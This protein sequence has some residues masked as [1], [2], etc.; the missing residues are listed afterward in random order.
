MTAQDAQARSSVG[1]QAIRGDD[2]AT[3]IG[4]TNPARE[5]QS[6]DRV[7]P[8]RTDHGTLPNLK[9]SFA[10]SHNRLEEGGWA[11]Q[12]TVREMPI[13]TTMAGVNMRLKAGA[14]REMH[15][16]KEA[17]WAFMLK[18]RA[19][20]TSVDQNL[21]TYQDDVG[22]GEGWNFPAG[23]PHS[24]QGLDDDGC[25]FL[26]VFDDGSFNEDETFLLTDWL[27][28]TPKE[29][30]SKNFGVP[31]SAFA[32]IPDKELYIFPSKVPGP[33]AADRVAGLGPVPVSFTHRMIRID[34]VS[35]KYGT[36]RIMDSTLFPAATTI[37][38]ALVEVE[39]GGMRELHWHPNADEWQ[40]HI[41]GQARMTVFASGGAAQ[42]FDYQAGDVG[43]VP[44]S[45]PHYL[46]NTAKTTFRF[47]E[48]FRSPKFEDVPLAQW[49]AFT[50][51]ELVRAHLKIDEAVLAKIPQRKMP[52]VGF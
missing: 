49:L 20:V 11:R 30:L 32:N 36:V 8:P 2:G 47:L 35:M 7:T 40:Y 15:W 41:A 43:Y 21:C 27:S 44:K 51:H 37:T 50:P 5:A 48:M 1:S 6:A 12:T 31:E 33:L 10:D 26:L 17:E 25:E 13:A 39:P 18:G 38:A 14:I 9:W 34:P 23:I 4:P 22:E 3:I 19:R 28:R 52:V 42:T 29:I 45:M 16:H 46:E 24:I